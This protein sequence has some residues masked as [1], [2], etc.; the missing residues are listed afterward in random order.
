MSVSFLCYLEGFSTFLLIIS[1]EYPFPS[2][3]R[4]L[5]SFAN[6]VIKIKKQRESSRHSLLTLF[7]NASLSHPCQLTA[8]SLYPGAS[9]VGNGNNPI[10]RRGI[11]ALRQLR[12]NSSSSSSSLYDRILRRPNPMLSGSEGRFVDRQQAVPGVA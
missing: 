8:V 4:F 2:F 7:V 9:A 3:F 10:G 5:L 6:T 11:A 12:C 1:F